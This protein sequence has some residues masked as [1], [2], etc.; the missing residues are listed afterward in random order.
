MEPFDLNK[1]TKA[2]TSKRNNAHTKTG[3]QLATVTRQLLAGRRPR[4]LREA[5]AGGRRKVWME[6]GR[7]DVVDG[8]GRARQAPPIKKLFMDD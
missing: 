6:D 7:E 4:A 1:Y 8:A 2:C 5:T 3:S